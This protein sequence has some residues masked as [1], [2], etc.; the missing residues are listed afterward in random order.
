M[1]GHDVDDRCRQASRCS[2]RSPSP[3]NAHRWVNAWGS[4]AW[5]GLVSGPTDSAAEECWWYDTLPE[6]ILSHGIP[7]KFIAD[8][9]QT[10]PQ[11]SPHAFLGRRGTKLTRKLLTFLCENC[12]K[13]HSFTQNTSKIFWGRPQTSAPRRL[14]CLDSAPSL[15]PRCIRRLGSRRLG[16]SVSSPTVFFL[17]RP[18]YNE[19]KTHYTQTVR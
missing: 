15:R 5:T 9:A 3:G 1:G 7:Q 2:T 12:T 10:P 19:H 13:M 8:V 16:D 11:T 17:I 4:T 18:L 14:Q 6:F